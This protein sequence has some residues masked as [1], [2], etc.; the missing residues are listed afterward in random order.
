MR[1]PR[2]RWTMLVAQEYDSAQPD[3]ARMLEQIKEKNYP[4]VI[5]SGA[6]NLSF[7]S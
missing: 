5:P 6:R 1:I 7:F 2:S 3:I 4:F